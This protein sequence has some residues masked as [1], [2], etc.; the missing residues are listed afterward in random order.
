MDEELISVTGETSGNSEDYQS[1]LSRHFHSAQEEPS[2]ENSGYSVINQGG[3]LTKI[4]ECLTSFERGVLHLVRSAQIL[5]THYG[6]EFLLI[7]DPEPRGRS[8]IFPT[9]EVRFQGSKL[10]TLTLQP[11]GEDDR[12]LYWAHDSHRIPLNAP[13]PLFLFERSPTAI[14][15]WVVFIA[16]YAEWGQIRRDIRASQAFQH[17]LGLVSDELSCELEILER[18][19]WR[20]A[21]SIYGYGAELDKAI[22]EEFRWLDGPDPEDECIN[23]GSCRLPCFRCDEEAHLKGTCRKVCC[24]EEA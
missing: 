8:S 14:A 18:E 15:M 20:V 23:D 7:F 3:V 5:L 13:H 24:L 11:G 21:N 2:N 6:N 17:F 4:P 16:E 10:I 1:W 22:E 9:L 19:T 12:T